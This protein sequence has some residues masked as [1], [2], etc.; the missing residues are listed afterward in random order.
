[1]AKIRFGSSYITQINATML[2]RIERDRLKCRSCFRRPEMDSLWVGKRRG[3][4]H[5]AYYCVPCA[6]DLH[7]MTKDE[8]KE[9]ISMM[10]LDQ[11]PQVIEV[12]VS[13]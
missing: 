12:I 7:I 11:I 5:A 6:L 2:S 1:M 10:N 8:L 3:S 9:A 4:Q 13:D